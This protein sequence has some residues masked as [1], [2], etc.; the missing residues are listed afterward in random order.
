MTLSNV[1]LKLIYSLYYRQLSFVITV[2]T[3][4]YNR[5]NNYKT[6]VNVA[7]KT[8]NN[9]DFQIELISNTMLAILDKTMYMYKR[10]QKKLYR[11]WMQKLN[12]SKS[13]AYILLVLTVTGDTERSK[14]FNPYRPDPGRGEKINLN[15]YFITAF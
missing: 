11:T 9:G 10:T 13:I 15:F 1:L 3:H 14:S 2:N 7:F 4:R 8:F 5:I 12:S 6:I